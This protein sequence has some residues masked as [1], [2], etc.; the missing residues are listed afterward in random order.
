[1]GSGSG[2][3]AGPVLYQGTT[4]SRAAGPQKRTGFSPCMAKPTTYLAMQKSGKG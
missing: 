1:V 2:A 4:F 3:V